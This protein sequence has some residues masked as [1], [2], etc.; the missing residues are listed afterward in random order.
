MLPCT[1]AYSDRQADRGRLFPRRKVC[2]MAYN[3][4]H[5]WNEDLTLYTTRNG[6]GD[7]LDWMMSRADRLD[8]DNVSTD[9]VQEDGEITGWWTIRDL[10]ENNGGKWELE[11]G[12]IVYDKEDDR[13]GE[14]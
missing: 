6:F 9:E 10:F 11:D 1:S 2:E 5:D 8:H 13:N 14:I 7:A 12:T 3:R 4:V